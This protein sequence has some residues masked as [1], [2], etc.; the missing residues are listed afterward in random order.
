[1]DWSRTRPQRRSLRVR[2]TPILDKP[3]RWETWAAPKG[4]DGKTDHNTA[5]TGDDL[6]DFVNQKLFPYL[7]RFT[8]KASGPNT[9]AARFAHACYRHRED[10]HR[11]SDRVEAVSKPLESE[12]RVFAPPAH[13][14]PCRPKYSGRS[15][16]QRLFSV[17]RGCI[18][19]QDMGISNATEPEAL[20]PN[21]PKHPLVILH[22]CVFETIIRSSGNFRTRFPV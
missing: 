12:P 14:L 17:P 15:S 22:H 7:H 11:I 5:M 4:K 1:M 8:Q 2:S 3:Y 10:V 20:G 19:A 18:G 16:L 9:I 21:F 13:P 6:R